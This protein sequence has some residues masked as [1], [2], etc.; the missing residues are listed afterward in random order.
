MMDRWQRHMEVHL[1]TIQRQLE[2]H[3]KQ[4]KEH[5]K[6]RELLKLF[7][8]PEQP[9]CTAFTLTYDVAQ[10]Q[11]DSDMLLSTCLEAA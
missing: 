11:A 10:V 9:A 5:S 6:F 4:Q 8:I 3:L 1:E 7:L 2:T